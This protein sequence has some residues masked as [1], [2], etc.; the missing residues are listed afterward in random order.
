MG[1]GGGVVEG[2]EDSVSIYSKGKTDKS[3][4]FSLKIGFLIDDLNYNFLEESAATFLVSRNS[5]KHQDVL[6]PLAQLYI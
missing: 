4:F 2:D 6:D 1:G 3:A 5:R